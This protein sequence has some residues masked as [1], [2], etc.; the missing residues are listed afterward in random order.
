[1]SGV[2]RFSHSQSLLKSKTRGNSCSSFH[3]GVS[4]NFFNL[5]S[6][7]FGFFF[8]QFLDF[9]IINI[10]STLFSINLEIDNI[11]KEFN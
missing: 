10:E 7:I 3:R 6:I 8:K 1:M 11:N 4:E 5:N 2:M 9:F